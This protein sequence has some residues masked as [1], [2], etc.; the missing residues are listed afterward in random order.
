MKQGIIVA[1]LCLTL[2]VGL[3][4]LAN[5]GPKDDVQGS[6][7]AILEI[8]RNKTLP[9]EESRKKISEV[10]HARFDFEG[11][12]QRTLA[13]N[14]KSATVEQRRRFTD[15]FAEILEQTYMG[16]IEAYTDEKVEYGDVK[17]KGKSAL[18]ET[19]IVTSS[20]TIPIHYKLTQEGPEWKVYDVVIEE[21]SLVRNYR[22]TYREIVK[23]DGFD[24]LFAK[25]EEKISEMKS[26]REQG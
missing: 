16:R 3:Q 22:D 10:I 5:A 24:G 21:V 15:L 4:G 1:C 6:V 14:W 8:L 7:D 12:A 26:G 19:S 9:K 11:M 18:V 25:M 23:K 13:T 17:T 2:F 20:V